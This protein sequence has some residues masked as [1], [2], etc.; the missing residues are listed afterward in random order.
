MDAFGEIGSGIYLLIAVFLIVLAILWFL[1]PFAVFGI[2]DILK[3]IRYTQGKILNEL[4]RINSANEEP[5][6]GLRADS[7]KRNL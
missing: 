6:T 1:L 3:D 2:K 4:Q 7:E 5:Q